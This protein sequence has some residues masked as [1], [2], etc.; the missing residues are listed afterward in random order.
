[1]RIRVIVLL[2]A[3]PSSLVHADWTPIGGSKTVDDYADVATL[4]RTGPTAKM[5]LLQD[6]Q[7]RQS[8]RGNGKQYGSAKVQIEFD[9]EGD[10]MRQVAVV[11]YAGRMGDGEAVFSNAAPLEWLP[12]VPESTGM[13]RWKIACAPAKGN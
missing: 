11:A 6:Y 7:V 4:R 5:W 12:V 1:M 9:C 8:L 3:L 13:A 2:L 10:R